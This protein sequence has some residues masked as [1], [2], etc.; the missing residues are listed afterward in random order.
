MNLKDEKSWK[1]WEEK[2][3]DP[4]GKAC[5]DYARDWMEAMDNALSASDSLPEEIVPQIYQ[6]CEPKDHGITG[7]MYGCAVE[8]V[9]RCWK[10]GEIVRKA[11]NIKWQI[12]NEGERANESDKVLNPAI[13]NIGTSEKTDG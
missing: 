5:V 9:S 12:G 4:Y 7:N 10:H 2:N 1:D 8:M 11:H 3:Q 6:E 13:I